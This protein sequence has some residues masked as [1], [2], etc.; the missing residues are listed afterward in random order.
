MP[1]IYD[2]KPRFQALLRPIVSALANH[3]IT[4]NQVTLSAVVISVLA[5]VCLYCWPT[6]AWALWL[7]P[8]TL[9]V[10]MALNAIDGLLARE[11]RM[12]SPLGAI[13]NELGDVVSD[14]ALYLPFAVIPGIEPGLV[15]GIVI[16]AVI[17]EMTGVVAVQIGSQRQYQGPMGKSDRALAFGLLAVLLASGVATGLWTQLY[18][19]M[20][21]LLLVLTIVNRARAAL[22]EVAA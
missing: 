5:G 14:A 2:L 10:R 11:H 16:L 9:F 3:G 19:G 21:L 4:A 7:I 20:V 13:L 17:S 6:E 8:V 15:V 22:A 18:L 1:S 12:Q